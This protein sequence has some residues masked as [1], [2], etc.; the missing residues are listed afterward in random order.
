MTMTAHQPAEDLSSLPREAIVRVPTVLKVFP[1]SRSTWMNGVKAGRYPK[2]IKVSE[3]GVGWRWGDI[4]DML[5]GK[6][7]AA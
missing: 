5:S 1:V 3:R 7:N 4:L 6:E 2:A